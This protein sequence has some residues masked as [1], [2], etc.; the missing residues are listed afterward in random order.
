MAK[1][2][3]PTHAHTAQAAP[4]HWLETSRSFELF[5]DG[6]SLNLDGTFN[7]WDVEIYSASE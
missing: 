1:G 3:P 4:M 2:S 6:S 7:A 5:A